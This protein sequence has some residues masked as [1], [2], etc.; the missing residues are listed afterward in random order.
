MFSSFVLINQDCIRHCGLSLLYA[1]SRKSLLAAYFL[2]NELLVHK[3]LKG[4]SGNLQNKAATSST[5]VWLVDPVKISTD[6]QPA[7]REKVDYE[8]L[9]RCGAATLLNGGTA[10]HVL[11]H[12]ISWTQVNVVSSYSTAGSFQNNQLMESP[13]LTRRNNR[14][15]FF[16]SFKS[17]QGNNKTSQQKEK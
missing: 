11:V 5:V 8:Y 12:M 7:S 9:W 16:C 3:E 2:D 4:C 10:T 13:I 14:R 1:T 6:R 15:I 17:E